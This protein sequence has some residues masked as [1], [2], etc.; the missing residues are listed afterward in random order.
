MNSTRSRRMRNATKHEVY[1]KRFVELMVCTFCLAVTVPGAHS[2]AKSATPARD[3]TVAALLVS[4]IHFDPFLDPA[5]VAQL[6]A[7]PAT[8]WGRI[9]SAAPSADREARHA[10]ME[11]ACPTRGEDTA[12]T[13][14]ESSLQDMRKEATGSKFVTVSGDLLAHSFDCKYKAA[15]PHAAPG[16]YRAFV[17][18]TLTF[19]VEE[20]RRALPGTPVYVALGNND[21]DCGD[22]RLDAHSEFLTSMAQEITKDVPVGERKTAEETFAAS[23]SYSVRLPAPIHRARLL[24]LDD[25]FMSGKYAT[26]GVK[27][28]TSV[29]GAQLAWLDKELT[30]ARNS[31]E[32]VWVMAHI[33]PGVDVYSSAKHLDEVC[34]GKGPR[35]FL[36]SEKLAEVVARFSD[37]IQLAVFAHTHM[38]EVRVLKSEGTGPGAAPEQ[39]VAVK[40]VSSISPINGNAPSFTVAR[41]DTASAMLKDYRVF[42]ASNATG[43]GATWHEEYD[44]AKTFHEAEFSPYGVGKEVAGFT[45]D[46]SGDKQESRD[47]VQNFYV[48]SSSLLGLIWPQYGC[49]MAN[50]SAQAF[51]ACVC[52]TTK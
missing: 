19:V 4:D 3:E 38:D 33:P 27:P 29:A 45:A 49:S 16:D 48:G 18:K 11:K 31:R 23:G 8:E 40:L 46:P 22:Y 21:S 26:C 50:D 43:V 47:Y 32:K 39:G 37:V 14:L 2:Q 34:S 6:A 12:Y 20:L 25:I 24:V 42:S 36:A 7:A 52:P 30:D 51:R 28:D 35:M 10:A 44:W 1:I 13:L 9:L 5:R 15:F 41:V 17:E